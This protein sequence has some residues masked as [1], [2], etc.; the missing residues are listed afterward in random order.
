MFL[1]L[2]AFASGCTALT[3]VEAVS[4]GVPAFRA[5]EEQQRRHHLADHGGAGHL[6]V[7]RD[8]RPG[9]GHPRAHGR[10]PGNLIG[11]RR[12]RAAHGDQP[13]RAATFGAAPVL[14]LQAFTAAILILAANTAFNGFPVLASLLGRDHFLPHQL[15]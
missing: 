12:R 13:D 3:G 6:H 4:N 2:R 15:A 7:L 1:C 10:R 5:A 11:L 8:H 9:D 14:S